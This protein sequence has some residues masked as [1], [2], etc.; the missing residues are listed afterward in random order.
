MFMEELLDCW[1]NSNDE[2]LVGIR[3]SYFPLLQKQEGLDEDELVDMLAFFINFSIG[4]KKLGQD[5]I[6]LKY[7]KRADLFLAGLESIGYKKGSYQK[8]KWK[9]ESCSLERI[10]YMAQRKVKGIDIN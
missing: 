9:K 2:M 4:F 7:K 6:S 5:E 8:D 10:V 1:K 3:D